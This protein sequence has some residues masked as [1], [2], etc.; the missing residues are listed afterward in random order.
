[1]VRT[2]A[3]S[4]AL[5]F[6]LLWSAGPAG[7]ATD[8][9]AD[10]SAN[11]PHG[12]GFP[13]VVRGHAFGNSLFCAAGG[14]V[15][16]GSVISTKILPNGCLSDSYSV[17]CGSQ[18]FSFE[19]EPGKPLPKPPRWLLQAEP[20]VM[21]KY[22]LADQKLSTAPK[23]AIAALD[24][25]LAREKGI[26]HL[27]RLRGLAQF[28]T[29]HPDLAVSDLDR[30]LALAPKWP[31]LRL[32]HAQAVGASGKTAKAVAELRALE[33]DQSPSWKH[34]GELL[35][36]ITY[37]LEQLGDPAAAKYKQRTCA[38]GVPAPPRRW[39]GRRSLT[40]GRPARAD[41]EGVAE[42]DPTVWN[43]GLVHARPRVVRTNR[44]P[45]GDAEEEAHGESVASQHLSSD[46]EVCPDDVSAGAGAGILFDAKPK[47][48]E[49][50]P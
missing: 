27:W 29:G 10:A 23:E 6:P 24:E 48:C 21:E 31:I 25:A 38:A 44:P 13:N 50:A 43:G 47:R 28:A 16:R 30:A 39:C 32:E 7:A 12:D 37:G 33:K 11:C 22:Q 46:L 42:S 49:S 18:K 3:F 34:W 5:L 36:G 1:M 41:S 45:V 15:T 9:G 17:S 4:F 20:A 40:T 19:V 14:Y 8:G 35:G 2:G 26:P